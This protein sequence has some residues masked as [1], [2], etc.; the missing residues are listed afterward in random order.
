MQEQD[1]PHLLGPLTLEEK[2]SMLAGAN[3]WAT[4][5]VARVSRPHKELKG[6]AKVALEP[7]ETRT[8]TLPIDMRALSFWD[9]GLHAWVAEPGAFQ[10]LVGASSADLRAQAGF[11]LM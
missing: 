5:P 6:F 11:T 4:P 1:I 9:D 7:G 10:V 2:I 8:V 3:F